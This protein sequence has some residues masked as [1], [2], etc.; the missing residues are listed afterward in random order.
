MGTDIDDLRIAVVGAGPAGLT[1]AWTLRELGY[2]RVT[3][4]E[5][6]AEVGGKVRS[7]TV[8]GQSYELGAYVVTEEYDTVL[9]LVQRHGLELREAPPRMVLDITGEHGPRGFGSWLLDERGVGESILALL[10]YLKLT[11]RY[12]ELYEPGLRRVPPELSTP[13]ATFQHDRMIEP[14]GLLFQPVFCSLGYGYYEEMP[15]LYPLKFMDR[16]KV[17][18][19]LRSALGV[20]QDWPKLFT[21][22]FQ[23]LWRAVA[24]DLPDVRTSTAVTALRRVRG[25]GPTRV[26]V[27]A[28]GVTEV[29]DHVIFAAS[30]DVARWLLDCTAEEEALLSQVRHLTYTATLFRAEDLDPLDGI[31]GYVAQH[32]TPA[33]R[34]RTLLVSSPHAGSKVYLAYQLAGDDQDGQLLQAW[35]REDVVALGGRVTEVLEHARW[36]YFPHVGPDAVAEGWH[37]RMDDLQAADGLSWVGGA[38]NFETVEDSA[39]QARALV[40]RYFRRSS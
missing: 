36:R 32:Q 28:N 22:G 15:A 31:T 40:E 12:A 23:G 24:S 20:D 11:R 16:S 13:F 33:T 35:L 34:G 2:D 26:E 6:E 14:V 17:G 4:F 1:A 29:F 7:V 3:V 37:A 30:P 10:R 38:L 9:N 19:V 8:D 21:E 39:A 25:D 5:R 18:I 27:T